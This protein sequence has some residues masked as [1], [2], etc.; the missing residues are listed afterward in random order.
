MILGLFAALMAWLIAQ[1]LPGSTV[2]RGITPPPRANVSDTGVAYV[3]GLADRGPSSLALG[4]TQEVT[5]L[6]DFVS[7]YGARQTYSALYDW[8]DTF[9]HEGGARARIGRVVGPGAAQATRNLLDGSAGTSLIAKAKSPGAWGNNLTVAVAVS[10]TYVISVFESGT[11]VETSPALTTQQDAVDWSNSTS[12]YLYI[13]LGASSLIPTT[14]AASALSGGT[15]DRASITDT[16]WQTARD[17][18]LPDFG[19]GQIV[20]VGRV[21]SAGH[22]QLIASA[23]AKGRFGVLDYGD[24]ATA[25]TILATLATDR[26]VSGSHSAAGYGPW[27]TIPPLPGATTVRTVPASALAA[28]VMSRN[29]GQGLSPNQPPAGAL[30]VAQ[31]VTGVT[32]TYSETDRASL[33]AAGFNVVRNIIGQG[34]VIFGARTLA[35][36]ASDSRWVWVN[37]ARFYTLLYS[38]ANQIASQYVLGEL[39]PRRVSSFAGA[40]AGML[41]EYWPDDLIGDT[42]AQAARVDTSAN[43]PATLDGGVLTAT[44]V[45]RM[46]GVAEQVNI[47]ITKVQATESVA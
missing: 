5:S 22:A 27:L 19:P 18:F 9:F 46:A 37:N 10:G 6:S 17:M 26:A 33:N 7:K 36:P 11:L 42:F 1:A 43:T 29:D 45:V 39:N 34:I 15:D 44:L 25:A 13:T 24:T 12:R 40:L 30:G 3:A 23:E 28:G 47:T 4:G 2:T 32:Q 21:S 8:L 16:Q 31:W 14:L 20:D 41:K 35:D 38:R